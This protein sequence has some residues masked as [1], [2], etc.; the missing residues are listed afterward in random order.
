MKF[1]LFLNENR[2][3][4]VIVYAHNESEV[5]QR[6]RE[7]AEREENNQKIIGYSRGE[8]T[9]IEPSEV[10]CFF[11]ERGQLIAL[12][13]KERVQIKKRLY[14]IEALL[15]SNFIKINQSSI[16][17]IN[18]IERF[19]VSIGASMTVLFKNGYRDYVSRRQT[20]KIKER[21]GI[22]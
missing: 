13:E 19:G 9:V 8:I 16:A 5:T 12:L 22:K 14:E 11:L 20:R 1:S 17:N 10:F 4:E 7:I 2:E 6:L 15:P 18:K 21:L 3:E